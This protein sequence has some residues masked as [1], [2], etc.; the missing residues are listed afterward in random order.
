MYSYGQ[1]LYM[2]SPYGTG[3]YLSPATI[4]AAWGLRRPTNNSP[5]LTHNPYPEDRTGTGLLVVVGN[6]C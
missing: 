4:Q 3:I 5:A 6:D 2:N 1:V